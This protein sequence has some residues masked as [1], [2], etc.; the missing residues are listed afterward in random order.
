M[1]G[2]EDIRLAVHNNPRLTTLC[3]SLE[4]MGEISSAHFIESAERVP[5]SKTESFRSIMA[6]LLTSIII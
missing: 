6:K 2:F 1:V 3:Q 4:R 5:A